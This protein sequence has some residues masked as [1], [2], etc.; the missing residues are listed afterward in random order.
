[1]PVFRLSK[2]AFRTG[3]ALIDFVAGTAYFVIGPLD[4]F[5]Q[6]NFDVLSDTLKIGKAF[7]PNFLEERLENMIL[8]PVRRLGKRRDL[9]KRRRR[10]CRSEISY[11]IR[12]SENRL[13][14]WRYLQGKQPFVDHVPEPVHDTGPI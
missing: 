14:I 12:L 6:G 5:R 3:D 9:R 2:P 4:Q 8:E 1:M 11:D 13:I 7:F 10:S